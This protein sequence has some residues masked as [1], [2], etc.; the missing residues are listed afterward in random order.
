[1]Q[2]RQTLRALSLGVLLVCAAPRLARG[3]SHSASTQ[4]GVC[5]ALQDP[6]V[7]PGLH[8]L[9]LTYCEAL[10]CD[11]PAE[12]H[13][14]CETAGV[15]ILADYEKLREGT[16]APAMPCIDS[17]VCPCWSAAEIAAIGATWTP[18]TAELI[19]Q[20][21]VDWSLTA[22]Y[23]VGT[24]VSVDAFQIALVEIPAWTAPVCS[25][26]STDGTEGSVESRDLTITQAQAQTCKTQLLEQ[27]AALLALGASVG[28]EGD[29]CPPRGP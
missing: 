1:M 20:T 18:S 3:E 15:Q 5:D 16:T 9:C 7:T 11:H 14:S 25:Y 10:D 12:A 4:A 17:D 21:A 6:S 29:P 2:T 19:S 28:C 26:F 8:G 13:D 24:G 22:L 27:Y 23:E